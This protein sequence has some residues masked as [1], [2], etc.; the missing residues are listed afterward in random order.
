MRAIDGGKTRKQEA[1]AR[2]TA[3]SAER[4]A[5]TL[6]LAQR[7]APHPADFVGH[8]L[9]ASGEKRPI[10]RHCEERSDEAIH[11]AVETWIASL[12]SQ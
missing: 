6:V 5:A 9:P 2:S 3:R 11:A 12:R 1:S 4:A 7:A 10:R 8:L